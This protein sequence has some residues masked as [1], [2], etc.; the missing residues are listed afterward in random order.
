MIG[1]CG[2]SMIFF[3]LAFIGLKEEEGSLY[4]NRNK[5]GI[6]TVNSAYLNLSRTSQ[7]IVNCPWKCIWKAKVPTKVVSFPWLVACQRSLPYSRKLGFQLCSRCIL[8]GK[9]LES[10]SHL[11]IHCPLTTQLWILF[12]NLA[13]L[14]R[15]CMLV[16]LI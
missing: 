13:G 3:L 5:N 10:N 15:L 11:F 16:L 12:L 7:P 4:W 6:Y 14:V 1:I 8:C 2:E 9:A